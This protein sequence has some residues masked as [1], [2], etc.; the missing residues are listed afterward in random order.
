M[1]RTDPYLLVQG[2][3]WGDVQFYGQWLLTAGEAEAF[4][5]QAY[6]DKQFEKQIESVCVCYIPDFGITA[7]SVMKRLME[8]RAMFLLD[9]NSED[10]EDFTMMA[11]MGFF[12]QRNQVY[13]MTLPC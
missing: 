1:E 11:E 3:A 9:L 10:G 8:H 2:P 5:K 6:A 12:A 7:T 4:W 13:Q